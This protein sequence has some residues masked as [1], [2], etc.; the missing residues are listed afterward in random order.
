[1][2]RATRYASPGDVPVNASHSR[3]TTGAS[4]RGGPCLCTTG[5]AMMQ[6]R[7]RV[8]TRLVRSARRSGVL[9]LRRPLTDC[10]PHTYGPYVEVASGGVSTASGAARNV[11]VCAASRAPRAPA[12]RL[13]GSD[14]P[15]GETG[16]G[17]GRQRKQSAALATALAFVPFSFPKSRLNKFYCC[18]ILKLWDSFFCF[19]DQ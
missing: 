7:G 17:V 1:M 10:L 18:Y 2:Q 16:G 8:W 11:C 6:P 5:A 9:T 4:S 15:N 19:K 14:V 12:R 3:I 13:S